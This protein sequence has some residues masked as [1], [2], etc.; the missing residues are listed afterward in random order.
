MK[1]QFQMKEH[2]LQ[3]HEQSSGG[4][5]CTVRT[6]VLC[7]ALDRTSIQCFQIS[8]QGLLL[9]SFSPLQCLGVIKSNYSAF[10]VLSLLPPDELQLLVILLLMSCF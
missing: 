4:S 8:S 9:H 7:Q 6:I 2:L 5:G 1:D 3:R 10:E